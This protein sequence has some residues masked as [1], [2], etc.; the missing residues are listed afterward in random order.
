MENR[1]GA[2]RDRRDDRVVRGSVFMRLVSNSV[3]VVF[4]LSIL[5]KFLEYVSYHYSLAWKVLRI[6]L[7]RDTVTYHRVCSLR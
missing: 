4:S 1:M 7:A 3:S 2:E 6:K 5:P